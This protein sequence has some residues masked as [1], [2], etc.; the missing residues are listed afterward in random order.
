V[1]LRIVT[2]LLRNEFGFEGLVMTDDL[3]M[4]AILTAFRLEDT[5]RLCLEAGNDIMM[6]CHRVPEIET[7]QR[8]LGT[9]PSNQIERAQQH[10]S[11]FKK[12]LSPP[13]QFSESAFHELNKEIADLRS[14]VVGV[15]EAGQVVRERQISPVERF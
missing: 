4:G 6:L 10:V 2:E 7:V 1:S 11:E 13:E 14:T 3:D 8:I 5:I 12:N 15:E 9:L